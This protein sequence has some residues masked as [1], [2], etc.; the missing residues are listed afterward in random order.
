LLW[1]D[2]IPKA[3]RKHPMARR[4]DTLATSAKQE[5]ARLEANLD[6]W[7]GEGIPQG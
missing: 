4:V 6:L 2:A 5:K 1:D 3:G 7:V